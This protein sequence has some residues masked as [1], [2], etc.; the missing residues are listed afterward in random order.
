MLRSIKQFYGLKLGASDGEI[1]QVQ[2]FYFDD[3]NWVVRYVVA[4]T[5]SWLLGRQV[6]LSPHAFGTLQQA[7]KVLRVGLTRKQIEDSPS[8]ALHK[9]VSRQYEED[10][11]RYYGWPYYWQG[12]GLWGLSGTPLLE[13]PPEILPAGSSPAG[14][15]VPAPADRHLRS[16]LAVNGYHIQASDGP[17][18]H[19]CDF[20]M[21][22]QSWAIRELVIKTGHRFSGKEVEVGMDQVS[23]IIYDQSAV[24]VNLTTEAVQQSPAHQLTPASAVH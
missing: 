24:S 18:G 21:D 6:L 14:E 23:G 7:G 16:T 1:G 9:P 12:D 8:I 22:D 15:P 4:E 11:Y 13:M 3:Q 20:V 17:I 2:D 5:G 10:Y 19:I